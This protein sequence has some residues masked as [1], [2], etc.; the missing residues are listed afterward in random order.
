[1]EYE[2]IIEKILASRVVG[3]SGLE[4]GENISPLKEIK[5]AFDGYGV[6]ETTDENGE[7]TYEEGT[8]EDLESFAIFIHK[9]SGQR[10]FEFPEHEVYSFTFG[11]MIQHRPKE[12]VC[13]YV[14]NDKV[15]DCFHVNPIEDSLTE[16]SGITAEM[17]M[18]ILQKLYDKYYS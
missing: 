5:I 7:I 10:R 13:I 3:D 17:V 2:E 14:W 6:T 12:E 16:D 8:N 18:T 4:I 1:M 11:N 15:L 9:N